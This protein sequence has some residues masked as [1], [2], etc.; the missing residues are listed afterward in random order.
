[1]IR[2]LAIALSAMLLS[3]VCAPVHAE[4][5]EPSPYPISWELDLDYNTPQR[6][7][8][9]P[10][11]TNTPVAYWYMTYTITNNT[12][13]ERV[14]LPFFELLT[15]DG[16]V[17][18]SD[19]SIP[20]NV[21]TAIK[22]REKN[23]FLEPAVLIG[24]ELRLGEDEARESVAIWREPMPEMG[25]FSIFAG[26]L[27]GEAVTIKDPKGNDV[28]LRKTLQLNYFIRGDE[29]YPGEDEIDVDANLW[30]MR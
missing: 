27:S 3:A 15:A 1:M 29:V 25:S 6:I 13:Q 23:E 19:K 2:I 20:G 16:Q 28:I 30:V 21:F 17:I 7:I 26:G 12:D 10:A 24:G 22:E 18:R 4:F 11:G 9:T 8:V 14:F 5:P